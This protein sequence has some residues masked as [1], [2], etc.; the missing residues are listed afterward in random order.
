MDII[1]FRLSGQNL[2]MICLVWPRCLDFVAPPSSGMLAVTRFPSSSTDGR[3]ARVPVLPFLSFLLSPSYK[4]RS[5]Q[6]EK[7]DG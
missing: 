4:W 5:E 6:V 1:S 3:S 2:W 7:E